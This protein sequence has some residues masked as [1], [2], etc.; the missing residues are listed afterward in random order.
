M[1]YANGITNQ[2]QPL[3]SI[4]SSAPQESKPVVPGSISGGTASST[5]GAEH[6]DLTSLSATGGLVSQSLEGSDVR[7]GKVASLQQAIATGNYNVPSSDV[8]DKIMQSLLE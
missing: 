4:S 8:A 5:P 7:A 2:Q 1:S 3:S 6:A